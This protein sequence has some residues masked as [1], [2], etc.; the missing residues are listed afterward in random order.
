VTWTLTEKDGGTFVRMEHSGF[1][2]QDEGGYRGM[3][4]GWPGIVGRLEAIAAK[5]G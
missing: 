2:P 4:G 1:R 5:Q 3:G